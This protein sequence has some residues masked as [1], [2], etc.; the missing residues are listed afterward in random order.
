MRAPTVPMPTQV[1]RAA[2]PADTLLVLLPGA[3]S[4]IDEFEQDGGW[5]SALRARRIA[6]DVMLADAHMGYYRDQSV[7][8]RLQADVFAQARAAGY[9]QVWLAGISL[10]GFGSLLN[11][12]AVPG[13]TSG[14]IV[15][16]PYL[17]EPP[18]IKQ[19]EAAGGLRR[20]QPPA[21]APDADDPLAEVE[22]RLWRWL[23]QHTAGEA[24][25]RP[26]LYLGY[27]TE[28]RFAQGHRLLAAA[29]PAERVF[30]TPGGHDWPQWRRLWLQ[31]LERVPL[32]RCA[33]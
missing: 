29:L 4:S 23:R 25:A 22:L 6:A 14:L 5:L 33:A 20:W 10:G 26:P 3:H 27:G 7:V 2:C 21:Q 13:R 19:I 31:V 9:R 28:D 1:V 11:E 12:W 15:L 30:T 16:A 8:D 24:G 32:P 18:L 17:G